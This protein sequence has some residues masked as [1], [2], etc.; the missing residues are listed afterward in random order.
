MRVEPNFMVEKRLPMVLA[1]RPRLLCWDYGI[2][3]ALYTP[4]AKLEFFVP[5][6]L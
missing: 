3:H 4:L 5:K 6:M 1:K 2:I